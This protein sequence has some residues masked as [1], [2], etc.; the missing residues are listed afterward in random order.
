MYKK[1][2]GTK[3]LMNRCDSSKNNK[4]GFVGTIKV[5]PNQM[6]IRSSKLRG[7][8]QVKHLL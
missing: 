7:K 3:Q 6:L 4:Y 2:T 8:Q 1:N 5:I